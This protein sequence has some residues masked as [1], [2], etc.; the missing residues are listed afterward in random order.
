MDSRQ[1]KKRSGVCGLGQE[2]NAAVLKDTKAAMEACTELTEGTVGKSL[3]QFLK[4]SIV[5]PGLGEKLAKAPLASVV[6]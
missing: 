5:D 6:T 3:E 4:K 1:A 2:F